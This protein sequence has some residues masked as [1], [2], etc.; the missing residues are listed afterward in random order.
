MSLGDRV[1]ET[2]WP[3]RGVAG[4]LGYL[5]LRPLSGLFGL[6]VGLRGLG[7][8]VGVLR[9]APRADAGGQ[10]RQPRRRRHRQDAARP[11]GWRARWRRTGCA[12]GSSRAATAA[13]ARA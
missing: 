3:R 8:R 5:A 12:P 1:R 4:Q 2:V 7:Y 10:R 6:G 9:G 11:C 13:R